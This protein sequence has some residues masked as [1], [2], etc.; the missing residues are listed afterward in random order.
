MTAPRMLVPAVGGEWQVPAPD[1]VARDYLLLALRLDQHR[2]GLVDVY[3]GPA[4]LK[5]QVD[6]EP[7]RLPARMRADAAELRERVDREIGH[8]PRGRWLDAQ[9]VA[10]ESQ[11]RSLSGDPAPYTERAAV[12]FGIRPVRRPEREFELAAATIDGLIPGRGSVADRLAAWDAASHVPAER[13]R[14]V[15]EAVIARSRERAR[16]PYGLPSGESLRLGF[17]RGQPWPGHAWYDG[18]YRSRIDLDR[19]QPMS[20][21]ALVGTIARLTY[22]GH[23]LERTW[24][25]ADLVVG[26]GRL[27]ASV[28]LIETPGWLVSDGAA[29]AGARL[30]SVLPDAA[31]L[32]VELLGL[33]GDPIAAREWAETTVAM[34]P[35]RAVLQAA[36]GNAALLRH[37]D[38][39]EPEAVLRYLRDVGLMA[40]DAASRSL[41]FIEHPL[42][43]NTAAVSTAGEDLLR[44]WLELVPE[45]DRIARFARL[46]HEPLTP[47]EI[48]AEIQAD[49]DPRTG[50]AAIVDQPAAHAASAAASG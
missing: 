6:L 13:M 45:A 46:L 26:S 21:D 29:G 20:L 47:A 3:Y 11:A 41:A 14:P 7:L 2:P 17:V 4:D 44:R 39:D 18:G 12:S 5:A 49:L 34:A 50:A 19:D 16:A 48:E 15:A 28:V 36:V 23:H 30:A 32:L 8:A 40:P 42:W 22:P 31:D 35:A 33:T 38:G 43:R 25:E 10:L 24:K 37:V 9:L 1:P 27:E